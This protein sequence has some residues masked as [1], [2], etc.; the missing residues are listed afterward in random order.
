[1]KGKKLEQYII[2]G[3]LNSKILSKININLITDEVVFTYE[4]IGHVE[5]KRVQLYNEVINMLPNIIYNPDY[6]YKDWNNRENTLVFI[7]SL[8]DEEK[9]DIVIKIAIENDDKHTKN[10]IITMIK[11][12]E[13]TFRK[14]HKNKAKNLLYKK[15]D[16]NE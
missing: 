5:E 1:M 16:K 2:V 11:I 12:G 15:L 7:S 4:R 8:N 3:K 13:K 14:I 10:S 6:I 9:I